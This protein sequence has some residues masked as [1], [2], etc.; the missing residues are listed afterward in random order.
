[1]TRTWAWS[2][3]SETKCELFVEDDDDD[4]GD[5]YGDD[6]DDDGDYDDCALSTLRAFAHRETTKARFGVREAHLKSEYF[7]D[8][9]IRD[10]VILTILH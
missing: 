9:I 8:V 5:D 7:D 1:M 10:D 4:A 3:N 2:S 6:D